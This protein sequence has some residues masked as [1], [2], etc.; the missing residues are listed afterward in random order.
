[1]TKHYLSILTSMTLLSGCASLNDSLVLGGTI[2]AA[3]GGL[4]GNQMGRGDPRS[5]AIGAVT[6]A[7]FGTLFGY[8]GYKDER[9][10]EKERLGRA[11]GKPN[12]PRVSSPEVRAIWVPDKIENDRFIGG[13]YIYVIEK[14]ATFR[15][16]GK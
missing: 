15:Q 1:M 14:P 2:G 10:K 16:E 4:I 3:G 13:H 9:R 12:Y 7:A 8:L 11:N 6:G 5:T